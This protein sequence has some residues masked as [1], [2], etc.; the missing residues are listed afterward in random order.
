M[1]VFAQL[2]GTATGDM[3]PSLLLFFDTQRYLFDCGE[4]T[5]R[6]CTERK[7]RLGKLD[8]IFVSD[9]TP[10]TVGGLPGTCT[11]LS[12]NERGG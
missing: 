6:L 10:D 2:L 9:V 5:Q 7:V 3:T 1:K 11:T 8:R 4:S 12:T